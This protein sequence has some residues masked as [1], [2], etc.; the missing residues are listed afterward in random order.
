MDSRSNRRRIA[1]LGLA[2]AA[3]VPLAACAGG[4]GG[5]GS[6]G[7]TGTDPETFTVMTANEN[8]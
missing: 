3:V 8:M 5:T 4:S 7:G 2:L 6:E 1:T